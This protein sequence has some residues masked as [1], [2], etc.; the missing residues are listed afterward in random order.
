MSNSSIVLEICPDAGLSTT[1]SPVPMT[2]ATKQ[3]TRSF[4]LLTTAAAATVS[5][6]TGVRLAI[7]YSTASP[8]PLRLSTMVFGVLTTAAMRTVTRSSTPPMTKAA[9]TGMNARRR[10]VMKFGGVSL[11]RFLNAE[12]Y[13]FPRCNRSGCSSWSSHSSWS[14][15]PSLGMDRDN[16]G[17]GSTCACAPE[18]Q[19]GVRAASL[20]SMPSAELWIG[21]GIVN[22]IDVD[23]EL[24]SN[25]ISRWCYTRKTRNNIASNNGRARGDL[26]N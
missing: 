13:R 12:E 15:R 17:H 18:K 22:V 7:W 5:F 1:A 9:T 19:A 4:T 2:A 3:A 8:V 6:V 14:G 20:S 21:S 11:R 23:I 24:W 26:R 16:A 10:A 25:P